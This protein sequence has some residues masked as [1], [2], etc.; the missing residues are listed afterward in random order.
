MADGSHCGLCG[1]YNNDKRADVASPKGCVYK[2]YGTTALSYRV[3]NAQCALSW[4]QQQ[5]IQT[6]EEQCVKHETIN[7]PLSSLANYQQSYSMMKHTYIYQGAKICISQ[8]PVVQC[9]PGFTPTSMSNISVRFVCLPE[10]RVSKLYEER[11]ER[12]ESPLEL[13]HQPVAFEAKMKQ[14]ISCGPPQV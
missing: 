14:P 12:G 8:K 3:K 11:I 4:Q 13:R 2:S 10:G 1:D 6:E 5:L 7:T 9:T